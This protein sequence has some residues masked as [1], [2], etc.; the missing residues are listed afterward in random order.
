MNL[1]SKLN[2]LLQGQDMLMKAATLP[3]AVRHNMYGL[4]EQIANGSK[5]ILETMKE[6]STIV[7]PSLPNP[8]DDIPF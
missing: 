4:P 1:Q 8:D 6:I 2:A 5:L 3:E 7:P